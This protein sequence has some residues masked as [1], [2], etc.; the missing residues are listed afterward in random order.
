MPL[1]VLQILIEADAKGLENTIKG[2]INTATG[3]INTINSQEVD[4]TSIF[5]RTVSPAIISGV[6]SML[7]F[8]ISQSLDFQQAMTTTGSAV[9]DTQQQIA[10]LSQQA[11]GM[12]AT[13]P[14]SGQDLANA[15]AQ[16]GTVFGKGSQATYDIAQAMA[17]LSTVMGE[18]LSQVVTASMGLFKQWGV[19]TESGAIAA[20]TD[21]M[22]GAN[23]TGLSIAAFASQF[24][25]ATSQLPA[26]DKNIKSINGDM[27]SFASLV[28][29]VGSDQAT[30]IFSS[31]ASSAQSAGG[32]LEQ[33]GIGFG[34]IQKALSSGNLVGLL[35]QAVAQIQKLPSTAASS[36]LGSSSYAAFTNLGQQLPTFAADEKAVAN[37][38]ESIKTAYDN[39]DTSLRK[40]MLDWNL[41]KADAIDVGTLFTPLI[42]AFADAAGA[43]LKDFG[44]DITTITK[45]IEGGHWGKLIVDELKIAAPFLENQIL[46]PLSSIPQLINQAFGGGIISNAEHKIQGL[47]GSLFGSENS[48]LSNALSATGFNF[49]QSQINAI[50]TQAGS[51]DMINS[52]ISAFSTGIKSGQYTSLTNT[53]HL[54][55]PAGSQGLTANMIAAQLY[56]QFQ[57]TTQ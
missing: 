6:A 12:S 25:Q 36:I 7:A 27:A 20:L 14:Q 50:D 26:A 45:D 52:L 4:W 24:Q 18:P 9:G 21:L 44:D 17:Q 1:E 39:S 10:Q 41:F 43:L 57:G 51:K 49:N 28:L 40:L 38:G 37:N 11:L 35:S 34:A 3:A 47:F 53:F 19:T 22:H 23:A 29:T 32:P 13:V 30:S 33:V 8:A 56:K 16:V 2:V 15:M 54:N 48:G 5:T 46:G 31:L 55:V 42:N